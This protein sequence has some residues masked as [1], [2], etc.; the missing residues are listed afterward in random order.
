MLKNAPDQIAN[1]IERMLRLGPTQ[2]LRMDELEAGNQPI[3]PGEVAWLPRCDW[4]D[5]IVI[6]Q[7]KRTIRIIA[8]RAT[9]PGTGAFSRLIT[10]IAKAV[11]S[12]LS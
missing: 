6:S 1:F 2:A 3:I 11:A 9:K 10:E 12:R 4:P 8:I 5:D 7:R